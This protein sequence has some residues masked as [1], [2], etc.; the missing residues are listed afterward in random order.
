MAKDIQAVNAELEA[1]DAHLFNGVCGIKNVEADEEHAVSVMQ[2][3]QR[4]YQ[5]FGFLHGGATLT[6][7]EAV[8]SRACD[9]RANNEFERPFG[10]N[11]NV[12][13]KKPGVKGVLTGYAE[14]EREEESANGSG[15]K[16]YWAVRAVDEAGD[17]VSEGTVLT[18]IVKLDYLEKKNA[19]RGMATPNP[20]EI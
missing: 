18:K 19:E 10:L 16:Q 15:R 11:V 9:L 7:L 3:E 14:L 6:L 12:W 17:V 2:I 8:A 1:K 5:P 20:V 4:L 13:H